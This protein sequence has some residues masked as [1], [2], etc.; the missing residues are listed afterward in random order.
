MPIAGVEQPQI[1]QIDDALRLSRFDGDYAFA[2]P[3]YRNE[4]TVYL[5][6]GNREIYDLRKLRN[7]YRY[8]QKRGELYFI[9]LLQDGKYVA[10]GDVTFWRDDMPIVID[11]PYR[12]R[13][14]GKKV[15]AALVRRAVELGYDCIYVND[16]YD[17]NIGSQK[18]FVS[19]GFVPVEK[20]N[21]GR[22]YKLT[23]R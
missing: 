7:M 17:Y 22:R 11:T 9:Q 16:I 3:W 6:D 21:N 20:T 10:I 4:E 2:L 14:I 19:A 15:V 8:L 12:N 13:G 23:L 18:C 5:V 1:I